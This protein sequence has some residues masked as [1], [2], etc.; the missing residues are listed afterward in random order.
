MRVRYPLSILKQTLRKFI[1]FLA[2]HGAGMLAAM[3]L[4]IL[5]TLAFIA[6]TNYVSSGRANHFDRR[7]ITFLRHHRGPAIVQDIA[8]DITAMGGPGCW[9]LVTGMISGYLV[10]E[11]RYYTAAWLVATVTS[12]AVFTIFLKGTIDRVP[13]G[14]MHEVNPI[15]Y[16]P[17]FPSG[18]SMMSA[19]VYLTLGVILA[20]LA[21]RRRTKAYILV[22]AG[23]IVF[24][25]GVS[26]VYLCIH[27]PTDVVAGWAAG[28]VWALLCW[29]VTERLRQVRRE[30]K[31]QLRAS[32]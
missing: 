24:L 5:G 32:L 6:I 26:R 8:T 11:H 12:G 18:H 19:M 4:M 21:P 23:L 14:N 17:S 2:G 29:V 7:V 10:F 27:W 30:R 22:M 28:V 13:P 16:Y 15:H 3:V 20:Q 1:D 31:L 25:V 9:L